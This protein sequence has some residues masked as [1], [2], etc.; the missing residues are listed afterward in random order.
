MGLC[1]GALPFIYGYLLANGNFKSAGFLLMA[2]FWFLTRVSTA[3]MK[4]YKD[5]TGDRLF[6]KKTFYLRYGGDM[7]AW[8]SIITSTIAY[9]GVV[10]V[11]LLLEPKTIVLFITLALASLLASRN[12]MLRLSLTKTR[13]EKRLNSIFHK[14]VFRHNQFEAAVLLCLVLSS[15]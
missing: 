12:I 5:A 2:L 10:A 13:S 9:I 6:N 15:K 1:Y 8:V 11:L 14:S 7:T 4:D 3:I